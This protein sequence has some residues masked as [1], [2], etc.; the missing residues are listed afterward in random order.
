MRLIIGE[1]VPKQIALRDPEAVAVKVA[2]AMTMLAKIGSPLVGLLNASGKAVL[3]L[4]GHR[5]QAEEKI[6]EEEIRTIIAEA[7]TAGVLEPGEKEMIAG[8]MRLGDRPVGAVMTPRREVDMLD[9]ADAPE[10]VRAALVESRH[11]RLPVYEND[12]DNVLGVVQAKD[13]LDACLS[14]KAPEIRQFVREAPV[15]PDSAD[16]LDVVSILKGSSVHIGLIHDEHGHFEGV[17]TAADILE[18]IVGVFRTEE[19]PAEPAAT[20]REDGSYLLSGW[21]PVDEFSELIVVPIPESRPY[22]TVAGYVLHEFGS[23]PAVGDSFNSHGW[24][25]EVLDMDGRRVD[26][27]L[28]TKIR[29]TRRAV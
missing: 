9:V 24:R 6:T 25:F 21:M 28:A 17:V 14:G 7:E 19:G 12:P 27:V 15:I 23:I 16:A 1:L 3:W 10:A 2:P 11:S 4:L 18:A 13:L 8:V 22:Y 26:K 5:E 29:A 20:R